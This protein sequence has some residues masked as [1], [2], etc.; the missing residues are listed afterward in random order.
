MAEQPSLPF[1]GSAGEA[2]PAAKPARRRIGPAGEPARP[3]RR[4]ARSVEAYIPRRVE[5]R[6]PDR[7]VALHTLPRSV[8][9]RPRM[10]S[11]DFLRNVAPRLL[12]ELEDRL[13][14][15]P[16]DV[17]A[18]A[19]P[20]TVEGYEIATLDAGQTFG[21]IAVFDAATGRCVGGCS[22]GTL[23]VEPAHRGRGLGAEILIHAFACAIK[24]PGDG[25]FYSPDGYANRSAAHRRA[26][27]RAVATGLDVP[28]EV[29]RDYPDLLVAAGVRQESLPPLGLSPESVDHQQGAAADLVG[30][31]LGSL[32]GGSSEKPEVHA[33]RT[34]GVSASS[35]GPGPDDMPRLRHASGRFP[36]ARAFVE[37]ELGRLPPAPTQRWDVR[38]SLGVLVASGGSEIEA[39]YGSIREF[40]VQPSPYSARAMSEYAAAIEVRGRLAS[41]WD[42]WEAEGTRGFAPV[43]VARRLSG[44]AL[45]ERVAEAIGAELLRP[46][47]RGA[48]LPYAVD[49]AARGFEFLGSRGRVYFDARFRGGDAREIVLHG[50]AVERR[51]LGTGSLV[52]EALRH[53]AEAVGGSVRIGP[54]VSSGSNSDFFMRF[55]W[56]CSPHDGEELPAPGGPG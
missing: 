38:D 10:A 30:L 40:R 50:L 56:A 47:A 18:S 3:S 12:A 52:M 55:E 23:I 2:K 17:R 46:V 54:E 1:F 36:T 13:Q 41:L 33:V 37:A 7:G 8:V 25:A 34:E 42:R 48:A 20:M 15:L 43:S 35:A 44:G 28:R 39:R 26:V 51:G 14:R 27:A 31:D 16:P 29:L 11:E 5:G 19:V 6:P 49:G 22:G 24:L 45:I 53:E 9:V 32:A 21:T 4:E